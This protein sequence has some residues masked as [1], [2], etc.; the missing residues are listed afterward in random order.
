MGSKPSLL[1]HG[2][3]MDETF[4]PL[5]GGRD[6]KSPPRLSRAWIGPDDLPIRLQIA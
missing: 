6:F 4:I 5:P 1:P 3:R 2:Y